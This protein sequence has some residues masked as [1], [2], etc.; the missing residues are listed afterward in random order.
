MQSMKN[1][2]F[3]L[4]F[5]LCLFSNQSM[6]LFQG[7]FEYKVITENLQPTPG[8][9]NK[10]EAA[11][12]ASTGYRFKKHSKVLCQQ[13][14]YGWRLTEVKNRGEIV[15]EPCEDKVES[16]ENYRCYVKNVTLKCGL[17]KRGW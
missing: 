14:G 5:V 13:I 11:K 17:T 8:C 12:Q 1:N 7:G 9:K 3:F 10:K 2:N 4:L 15:C 6:A 16:I